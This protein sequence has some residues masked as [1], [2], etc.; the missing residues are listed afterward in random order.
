[1]TLSLRFQAVRDYSFAS[2]T[3]LAQLTG[4]LRTGGMCFSSS[5]CTYLK[6]ML[7]IQIA[8]TFFPW[9]HRHGCSAAFR[10]ALSVAGSS[11]WHTTSVA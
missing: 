9:T 2:W 8:L 3:I 1:M 11:V 5:A 4:I 10:L 7:L 6:A